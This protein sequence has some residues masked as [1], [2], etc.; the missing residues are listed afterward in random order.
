MQPSQQ[1]Y[2]FQCFSPSPF[3]SPAVLPKLL[4]RLLARENLLKKIRRS[5]VELPRK[6]AER[7]MSQQQVSRQH[8]SKH[9]R[10]RWKSRVGRK[11]REGDA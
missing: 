10:W 11:L 9:L 1:S 8:G 3:F 4:A 7:K 2:F 6:P 5:S